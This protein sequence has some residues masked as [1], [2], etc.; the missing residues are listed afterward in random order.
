MKVLGP[1]ATTVIGVGSVVVLSSGTAYAF[2]SGGFGTGSG[3][4]TAGAPAT[5]NATAATLSGTLYPGRN[6][7]LQV[8]VA[9]PYANMALTITGVAAAG[10][11][12]ATGGTGC[13]GANSD[14]SVNTSASSFSPTTI[15]GGDTKVVTITGAVKMGLNSA[16]GCQGAQFT[17]PVSVNV[18]V[19]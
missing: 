19:G 9:N 7:S 1:V 2:F 13:T 4:A 16:N 12:Q 5:I 14:V 15:A 6:A 10:T 18:K 8:T 17:V 11:V 3:S